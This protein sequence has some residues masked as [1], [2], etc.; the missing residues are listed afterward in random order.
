MMIVQFMF[1]RLDYHNG[2]KFLDRQALTNSADP[3]QGLH[4]LL[5]HLHS[6]DKISLCFVLF[7]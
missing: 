7:V 5:F 4:C 6:F 3:D 1:S 2:S